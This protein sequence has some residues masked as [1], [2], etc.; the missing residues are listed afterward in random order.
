MILNI[1]ARYLHGTIMCTFKSD[2]SNCFFCILCIL[3]YYLK[4]PYYLT[5]DHFCI[6]IY[7]FV[8][9]SRP[10]GGLHAKE[11]VTVITAPFIVL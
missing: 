6:I 3:Y 2:Y 7:G 1:N 10:G 5:E 4:S 11:D 9:N 8:I